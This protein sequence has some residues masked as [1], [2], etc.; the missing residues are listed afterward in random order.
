MAEL[1]SPFVFWAQ[2]DKNVTLKVDLKD[3]TEPWVDMK[4]DSLAFSAI[5]KGARGQHKY[6]FKLNFD[7]KILA[8]VS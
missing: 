7:R 3:A 5:G 1:P 4:N 2:T 6:Y 8:D